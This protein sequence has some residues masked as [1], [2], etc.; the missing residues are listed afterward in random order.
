MNEVFKGKL[1]IGPC[2]CL[3]FQRPSGN[4][5]VEFGIDVNGLE[6]RKGG[7][8]SPTGGI[9]MVDCVANWVLD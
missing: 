3:K 7:L 4:G 6:A 9:P 2:D 5:V 1:F 8:V